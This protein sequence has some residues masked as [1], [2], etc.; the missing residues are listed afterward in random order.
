MLG[1]VTYLLCILIY[2]KSVILWRSGFT[3]YSMSPSCDSLDAGRFNIHDD[4]MDHT[5]RRTLSVSV[6]FYPKIPPCL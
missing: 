5:D 2:N 6:P 3:F 4:T 1:G